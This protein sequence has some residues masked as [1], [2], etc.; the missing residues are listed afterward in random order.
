[1]ATT[2]SPTK[3]AGLDKSACGGRG[4]IRS[5]SWED[6]NVPQRREGRP[7]WSGWTVR[8]HPSQDCK[9]PAVFFGGGFDQIATMSDL[10]WK[11]LRG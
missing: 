2:V 7:G 3:W 6:V 9:A 8:P 10:C 11:W 1:M 5:S 4:G